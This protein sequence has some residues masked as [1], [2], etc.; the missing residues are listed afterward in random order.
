MAFG[1][2][3]PYAYPRGASD[4]GQEEPMQKAP[5]AASAPHSVAGL[6]T[7][8]A[9]APDQQ[10]TALPERIRMGGG[11]STRRLTER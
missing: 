5:P 7:L 6:P 3:P 4:P 1:R 2:G 9:I 10:L 11:P 8:A